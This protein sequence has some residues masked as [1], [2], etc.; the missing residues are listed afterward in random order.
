MKAGRA[1]G[2]GGSTAGGGRGDGG[3]KTPRFKAT[4][5]KSRES[6]SWDEVKKS[7]QRSKKT[8]RRSGRNPQ[9]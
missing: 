6:H 8:K 7:G 2:S 1:E 3:G 5:R 9:A 4:S